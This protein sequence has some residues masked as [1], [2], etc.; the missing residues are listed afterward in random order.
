[1]AEPAGEGKSGN[2]RGRDKTTVDKMTEPPQVGSRGYQREE[3]RKNGRGKRHEKGDP[4][5]RIS[6]GVTESKKREKGERI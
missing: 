4:G 5:E 3:G 1:V 6:N 2:A